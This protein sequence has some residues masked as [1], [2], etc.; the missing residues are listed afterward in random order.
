MLLIMVIISL[1]FQRVNLIMKQHAA[2][3]SK[4]RNSLGVFK[5]NRSPD[6]VLLNLVLREA[7]LIER[8]LEVVMLLTEEALQV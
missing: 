6:W 7:F 4:E 8:H 1:F 5:V 3:G 2:S